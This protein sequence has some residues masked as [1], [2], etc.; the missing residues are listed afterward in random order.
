MGSILLG[1]MMMQ[2]C[3]GQEE[4][5]AKYGEELTESKVYKTYVKY[6]VEGGGEPWDPNQNPVLPRDA[7][8]E[9]N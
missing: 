8:P 7:M 5:E 3:G 1:I 4:A 2:F 6:V 9:Y